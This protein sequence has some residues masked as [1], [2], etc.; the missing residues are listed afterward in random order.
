MDESHV[1][2]RYRNYRDDAQHQILKL[3]GAELLRRFL[4]H[5]LPRGF[6]RV[7]YY[8]YLANV[9]RRKKLAVIRCAL[10]N[11]RCAVGR[12][13]KRRRAAPIPSMRCSVCGGTMRL[14]AEIPPASA[15]R[16]QIPD[17]G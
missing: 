9:H 12:R 1:W 17:T 16:P 5:L 11:N 8:G 14:V 10:A 4:L 2:I 13:T 15:P 3:E 6:M 7:R